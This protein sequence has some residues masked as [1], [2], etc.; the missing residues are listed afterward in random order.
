[1]KPP[2]LNRSVPGLLFGGLVK[3]SGGGFYSDFCS[4]AFSSIF[5]QPQPDLELPEGFIGPKEHFF[6]AIKKTP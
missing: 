4:E 5:S 1:M 2:P 6:Q 3:I